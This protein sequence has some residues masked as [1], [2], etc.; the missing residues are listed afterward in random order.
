MTRRWG[1]VHFSASRRDPQ[2]RRYPKTWTCPLPPSAAV[3]PKTWTGPPWPRRYE[4]RTRPR[5]TR[6]EDWSIFRPTGVTPSARG[7]ETWTCPLPPVSGRARRQGGERAKLFGTIICAIL[8]LPAS[9][10]VALGRNFPAADCL[11]AG[12]GEDS[13]G[14]VPIFAGTIAERWSA[15]MGLSPL[16]LVTLPPLEP[17][18]TRRRLPAA[19][20]PASPNTVVRGGRPRPISSSWIGSAASTRRSFQPWRAT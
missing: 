19:R 15:K 10:R 12:D 1:L 16:P 18:A 11:L 4:W 6:G 14:T 2:V 13:S 7:S 9:F 17:G 3:T 5:R 8:L 20:L